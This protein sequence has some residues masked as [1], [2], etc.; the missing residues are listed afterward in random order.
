[1]KINYYMLCILALSLLFP[2]VTA[3]TNIRQFDSIPVIKPKRNKNLYQFEKPGLTEILFHNNRPE[4]VQ[5]RNAIFRDAGFNLITGA[6]GVGVGSSNAVYWKSGGTIKS[7]NVP[8]EW[9]IDLYCEGSVEKERERVKND[10]GSWSVETN[11]TNEFFWDRDASGDIVEKKDTIGYFRII[12]NPHGNSLLGTMAD[13][14]FSQPESKIIS[15]SQNKLFKS[16][17][18]NFAPDYGI[19]GVI[20]NREFTLISSGRALK[21]W[22]FS[23]NDL[24]GVFQPDVDD[25]PTI[26]KRDRISP[27][28]LAFKSKMTQQDM[29]DLY[30]LS[31]MS[32]LLSI[33]LR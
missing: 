3:Q 28:L 33:T 18:L 4:K 7:N 8:D 14:V 30:R 6:T 5:Y 17:F 25:I 32:R 26:R 15:D 21:T 11:V 1:M 20:R 2:A 16:F 24:W 13:Y 27:Y 29:D 12:M 23:G 31:V 22:I 19:K 9:Q 10:D